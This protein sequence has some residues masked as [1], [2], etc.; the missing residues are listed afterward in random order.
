MALLCLSTDMV[1]GCLGDVRRGL[2][3]GLSVKEVHHHEHHA[4]LHQHM[5]NDTIREIR[6]R[7]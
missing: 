1:W 2:L 4:Q 7:K 6:K 3:G 5:E